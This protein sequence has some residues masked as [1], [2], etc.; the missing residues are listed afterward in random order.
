MAE[1]EYVFQSEKLYKGGGTTFSLEQGLANRFK[2]LISN[3]IDGFFNV[4]WGN[5]GTN[6]DNGLRQSLLPNTSDPLIG[7]DKFEEIV[8]NTTNQF[9]NFIKIR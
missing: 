3:D 8:E 7:K 9:Y 2:K 6:G 1:L 4:I 5:T